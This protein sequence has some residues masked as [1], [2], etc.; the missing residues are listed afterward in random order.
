MA[1]GA[2]PVVSDI[3][4]NREWVTQRTG[5]GE[6]GGARGAAQLFATGDASGL[7]GAIE[8]AL[9]DTSWAEQARARNVAVIAARGDWHANLARIEACFAAL[10]RGRPLPPA[11]PA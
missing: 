2:L 3:E 7:A 6:A 4:G 11:E 8:R 9:T 1:A 5:E 10:A